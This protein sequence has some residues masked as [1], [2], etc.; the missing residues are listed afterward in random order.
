[1]SYKLKM[2]LPC[3]WLKKDSRYLD[4]ILIHISDRESKQLSGQMYPTQ[5]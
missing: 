4:Q 1:M 5:N 2:V 3:H